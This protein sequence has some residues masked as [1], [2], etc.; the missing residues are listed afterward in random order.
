MSYH[1]WKKLSEIFNGR[2]YL[3]DDEDIDKCY[4]AREYISHG[5]YN[6]SD[7]NNLIQN[8]K[9]GSHVPE[10]RLH[11]R[12]NAIE[13]FATE[14]LELFNSS[15]FI[16]QIIIVIPSSKIKTDVEYDDRMD[17]VCLILKNNVN[18]QILEPI[19]RKS[20]RLARHT[21]SDK[22]DIDTEYNELEWISDELGNLDNGN[23]TVIIL[24]DV[25]TSGASYKAC[26]KIIH[27]HYPNLEVYG[28]FWAVT[29]S[30]FGF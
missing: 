16:N 29:V 14:L 23:A 5:G 9:M 25:I 8:F 24:D 11:Y 1:K 15:D 13:I 2:P 19:R 17:K 6:A 3:L 12:N 21:M 26:K 22:R 27:E 30:N 18:I 20:S 4:V 28:V 7:T 10:S